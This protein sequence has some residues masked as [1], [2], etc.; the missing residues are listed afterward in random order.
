MSGIQKLQQIASTP[1]KSRPEKE[2]LSTD[3]VGQT[4][5]HNNNYKPGH[6][7]VTV[8]HQKGKPNQTV[9]NIRETEEKIACGLKETS[10]Q[11]EEISKKHWIETAPKMAS[12]L[13]VDSSKAI[14]QQNSGRYSNAVL[15]RSYDFNGLGYDLSSRNRTSRDIRF[16]DEPM[17]TQTINQALHQRTRS[18][19]PIRDRPPHNAPYHGLGDSYRPVYTR[20]KD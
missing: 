18:R 16:Q 6:Y 8:M 17:F 7:S 4:S 20:S 11:V 15:P 13:P 10:V 5:V 3:R 9:E 19:L 1:P 14:A 12:H 2:L